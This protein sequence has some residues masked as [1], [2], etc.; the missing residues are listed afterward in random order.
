MCPFGDFSVPKCLMLA[1]FPSNMRHLGDFSTQEASLRRP[2]RKE[3]HHFGNFFIHNASFGKLFNENPLLFNE[4]MHF[5][6]RAQ[7]QTRKQNIQRKS[8]IH[9]IHSFIHSFLF[10]LLPRTWPGGMRGAIESAALAVWQALACQIE[11]TS[12]NSPISNLQISNPPQI[13]SQR[14]RAFRPAAPKDA[15]TWFC[16][17][18]KTLASAERGAKNLFPTDIDVNLHQKFKLQDTTFIIFMFQLTFR[19]I[20]F[21]KSASR[22]SGEHIFEKQLQALSIIF[23]TFFPPKRPQKEH[24]FPLYLL[25]SLFWPFR[26][27]FFRFLSPLEF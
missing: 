2:S 27:L 14:P 25:F 10:F 5:D 11:S 21:Q 20:F 13:S 22:L 4:N 15:R 16:D 3:I 7:I 17:F 23:F 24:F 8:E 26:S 18:Q 9:Q 19:I 1:P 12:P 6:M